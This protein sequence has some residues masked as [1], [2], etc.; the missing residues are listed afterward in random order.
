[1]QNRE[2]GTDVQ[3]RL[4]DS[5]GEGEGGMFWEN[6]I[7]TCI[8][9]IV[10]QITSPGGMH[11]ISARACC[12]GKT[13]RNQ[14]ERGRWEGG[15]GWGIHVNPWLIHVNVWQN[16]LQYCKV[17]SLQLLKINGKKM[18]YKKKK[19]KSM[20]QSLKTGR[21][22]G[23]WFLLHPHSTHLHGLCR[24]YTHL[25]EWQWIL[26]L[27]QVVNTTA[28]AALGMILFL[29]KSTYSWHKVWSYRPE[30]EIIINNKHSATGPAIH[31]HCAYL[32]ILL[33]LV[34]I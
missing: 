31:F 22:Q 28:A 24:R 10:K 14:V 26:Q 11:E 27:I 17:I 21:S 20:I 2:R 25:G 30:N 12:T 19:T 3:N 29:K 32:L 18:Y 16:P 9:S 15:S 13:Q 1:M 33:L 5:V 7:E 34:I 4:W 8:L 6:S 23:W